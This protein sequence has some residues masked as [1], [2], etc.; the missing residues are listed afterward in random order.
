MR[1]SEDDIRD[2]IDRSGYVL[3]LRI[4]PVFEDYGFHVESSAQFEDQDTGK[5][6]ELD[7]HAWH[8]D[9]H[10]DRDHPTIPNFVLSDHINT[11]IVV[12]CKNTT[13]PWVLF[14]KKERHPN[15][16]TLL[17]GG[18]PAMLKEFDEDFGEEI[19][20]PL[21]QE[22]GLENFHQN[23][24][25]EYQAH[26]FARLES[27]T[28]NRGSKSNEKVD[29]RLSHT[30]MNDAIEKVCK[31][32]QAIMET[33]KK[34]AETE[35]H[36]ISEYSFHV[37]YPLVVFSGD[38]YEC[39]VTKGSYELIRQNHIQLNWNIESSQFRQDYRIHIVHESALGEFL[40][41]VQKDHEEMKSQITRNLQRVYSSVK[42]YA[43]KSGENKTQHHKFD[44]AGGSEA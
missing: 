11:D 41:R 34:E 31:A 30:G 35:E 9:F 4:C 12:E 44:R 18:N 37:I 17:L 25:V 33:R 16:G 21:D 39:R 2:A 6:R 29:W 36:G 3:E 19:E 23:W 43:E 10:N 32:C 15:I 38:L 27:K 5:S 7:L 8:W 24:N 13:A 28:H 26:K 40:E 1:P 20:L 42:P 22:F 14:T